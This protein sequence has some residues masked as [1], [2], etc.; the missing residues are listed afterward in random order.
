MALLISTATLLVAAIISGIIYGAIPH[1][2]GNYISILIGIIIAL[3]APLNHLVTQFH[4]EIFMYIIAPLIY[5]E[6]QTTRIHFVGNWLRQI[7]ETAVLLVIVSMIVAGFSVYL[8]GISLAISFVIAAIS[9]PTDATATETV[10]E[11]QIMPA[12][13]GKLLRVEALFN[14]AT[15]IVLVEAMALWVR[16]GHFEYQEAFTNFLISAGGGILVG[17]VFGLAMISFRQGLRQFSRSTYNAQD[18]LFLITPFFIYFVAEELGVSGII[19]VV[20]AG[21]M[22]NSESSRSRFAHPR[23]F[24][25]GLMLID[26][27]REI[28]NNIIFVV[29]GILIVRIV[30][31]DLIAAD[32]DLKWVTAGIVLYLVM[33]VVRYGYGRLVRMT[34]KG[35]LIFA[36]GGV[37]GAVTLALVFSVANSLTER[38][39]QFVI[40]T[41]MLLVLL[42][43]VV[44]S[45]VFRFIL[46]A[47]I[48]DQVIQQRIDNLRREMVLEG[49][50]AVNKM[51]LPANVKDSVLYDLRD[52]KG[53]TTFKDFWQQWSKNSWND[54]F[55]PEE[56]D[57]ERQ[58]LLWAFRAERRYLNMIAQREELRQYVFELYNEVVLSESI[59]VDPQNNRN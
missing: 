43:M 49:I 50:N 45:L 9:T 46:R 23:Q 47:D 39:F 5:F 42:S 12:R 21:L 24:H 34:T 33:L 51:Y 41:E 30:K 31:A 36:L 17:I 37:H 11:G 1:I 44:P 58:A 54:E 55:T 25:N 8:C 16:A 48:P 53:V 29:L 10:S 15:G 18:M 13:Q 32:L 4:S 19:A 38:Q 3:I 27:V 6:G 35:S 20:C 2:P 52:Q 28:L 59:L 56:R 7:I 40:M 22:Q 26:L 57:L 14:D